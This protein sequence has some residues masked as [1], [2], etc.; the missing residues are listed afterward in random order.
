MPAQFSRIRIDLLLPRSFAC[1]RCCCCGSGCCCCSGCCWHFRHPP[2]R[3]LQLHLP[4]LSEHLKR[5]SLCV[6]SA[7]GSSIFLLS[8]LQLNMIPR[9]LLLLSTFFYSAFPCIFSKHPALLGI[10]RRHALRLPV[11]PRMAPRLTVRMRG[12]VS[13]LPKS[14][15]PPLHLRVLHHLINL[16]P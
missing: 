9:C 3:H 1:R 5:T 15:L 14:S 6:G 4:S 10:L 2:W 11:G 7:P 8:L 16:H 13:G 12:A